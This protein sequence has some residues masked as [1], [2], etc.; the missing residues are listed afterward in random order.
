[1]FKDAIRMTDELAQSLTTFFDNINEV[2]FF[3]THPKLIFYY[4]Y[5]RS[6]WIATLGICICILCYVV[7]ENKKAI[8]MIKNIIFAYI[9]ILCLQGFFL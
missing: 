6:F 3:I 5:L 1:M 7:T 8:M 9:V 4:I 2:W